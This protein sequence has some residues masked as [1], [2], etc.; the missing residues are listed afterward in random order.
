MAK[1]EEKSKG[2][3]YTKQ[4]GAIRVAVWEAQ[5]ASGKNYHNVTI[6]RRY[7]DGDTWKDSGTLNGLGDCCTAIEALQQASQ[8]ISSRDEEVNG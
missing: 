8:F 1:K 2:P 3:I 4:V 6:T 7:R 5:T